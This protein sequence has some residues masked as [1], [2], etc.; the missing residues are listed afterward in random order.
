MT[1]FPNLVYTI[2]FSS[3]AHFFVCSK[4]VEEFF[5]KRNFGAFPPENPFYD[6][7]EQTSTVVMVL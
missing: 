4:V 3:W 5:N 2:T 1:N 6:D 7:I